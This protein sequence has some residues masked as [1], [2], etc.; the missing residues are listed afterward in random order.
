MILEEERKFYQ[1][2]ASNRLCKGP[3]K[4]SHETTRWELE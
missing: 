4:H 3:Y 1:T 2:R